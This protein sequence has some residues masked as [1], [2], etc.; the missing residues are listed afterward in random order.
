MF[1]KLHQLFDVH[2]FYK[3]RIVIDHQD[4]LAIII[5]LLWQRN[6][7]DQLSFEVYRDGEYRTINV[8]LSK[9]E[10]E[11]DALPYGQPK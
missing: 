10:P 5:Q 1:L 3:H 8:V 2:H 7:G 4:F 6:P 11:Q 9:V